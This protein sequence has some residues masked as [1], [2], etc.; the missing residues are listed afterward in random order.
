MTAWDEYL[1]AFGAVHDAM[2]RIVK[3]Y[4]GP[5][6]AEYEEKDV[7]FTTH[8]LANLWTGLEM[9]RKL[10]AKDPAR[11]KAHAAL[12]SQSGV[13]TPGEGVE[14]VKIG[15]RK[16]PAWVDALEGGTFSRDLRRLSDAVE[17]LG[18]KVESMTFLEL[19]AESRTRRTPENK[20]KRWHRRESKPARKETGRK[21]RHGAKAKLGQGRLD[22]LDRRGSKGTEGRLTH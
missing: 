6:Y 22:A 16:F 8:W 3:R 9:S 19:V 10:Q 18:R 21:E 11:A 2:S 17:R 5:E 13:L 7:R 14:G 4:R 12:F 1:A 15:A 20:R